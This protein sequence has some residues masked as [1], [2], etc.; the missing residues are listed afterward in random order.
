MPARLA[1]S[2][3][4]APEIPRSAITDIAAA[5]TASRRSSAVERVRGVAAIRCEYALTHTSCQVLSRASAPRSDFANWPA[6][7]ADCDHACRDVARD[8]APR[9][10]H[11]P[12]PH[13]YSWTQHCGAADPDVVLDDDRFAVLEL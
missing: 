6:W 12:G 8:D 13:R 1:T 9:S 7:V 4:G 3:V 5:K 10:D 11:G 2:A